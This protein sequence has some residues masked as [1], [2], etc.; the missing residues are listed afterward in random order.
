MNT[1]ITSASATYRFA[2]SNG[3][4]ESLELTYRDMD[5]FHLS[6]PA[7][8]YYRKHGTDGGTIWFREVKPDRWFNAFH[9]MRMGETLPS[10]CILN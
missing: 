6:M 10:D 2:L 9:A 5:P 8:V 7:N 1:I 4:S 3:E